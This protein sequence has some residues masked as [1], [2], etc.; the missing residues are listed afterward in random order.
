MSLSAVLSPDSAAA[1]F[2]GRSWPVY[3][4]IGILRSVRVAADRV[5]LSGEGRAS[6]CSSVVSHSSCRDGL[7][8]AGF[9]DVRVDLDRLLLSSWVGCGAA[10]CRRDEDAS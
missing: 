9:K 7:R 3:A 2:S 4:E 6:G 5:L 10:E 8:S 1:R